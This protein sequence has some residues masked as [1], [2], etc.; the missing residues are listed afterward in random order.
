M[1]DAFFFCTISSVGKKNTWLLPDIIY[2]R[3]MPDKSEVIE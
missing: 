3:I 1:E 2:N